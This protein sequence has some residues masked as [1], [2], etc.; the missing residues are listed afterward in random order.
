M[1]FLLTFYVF[2]ELKQVK[3]SKKHPKTSKN[4]QKHLKHDC[5]VNYTVPLSYLWP[6]TFESL[7]LLAD[8]AT[9]GLWPLRSC[10]FWRAQ[11]ALTFV[12]PFEILWLLA[13]TATFD[14]WPLRSYGFWRTSLPL[15]F[16]FLWL[17]ANIA[18]LDLWDL[19]ASGGH[20]Y[21]WPL[22]SYGFWRT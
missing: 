22:R 3:T 8:I 19:M 21:L 16:E 20:R 15:T 6:L 14:L 11:L 10:G 17:L 1:G 13:D 9:F 5:Q 2:L 18:T 12:W 4:I 7:W